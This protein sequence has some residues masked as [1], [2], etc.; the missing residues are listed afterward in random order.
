MKKYNITGMS[1]AACSTRIEKAVSNLDGVESCN[2]NL[3]TNSM[4]VSGNVSEEIIIETVKKTGYGASLDGEKKVTK[5]EDNDTKKLLKRLVLSLVFLVIL[6]YFSM[7]HMMFG[8][9]IPKFFEKNHVALGILEMLLTIVIMLI[10]NKFFTNG[11]KNLVRLSPNMDSLIAIGSGI[12]FAYSLYALFGLSEAVRVGNTEQAMKY[13]DNFHFETAAMI[14]TLITVGKTLESF[15]KGKTTNALKGLM[16]LTPKIATIVKDDKNIVVSIDEVRV[17]DIFLVRAGDIVP[18]DGVIIKGNGTIDESSLTGESIPIDKIVGDKVT[19]GTI[20]KSGF[21]NC[22]AEKVCEDTTL[23]QIIKMVEDAS[24]SKAPIAKIADKVAGIFVPVVI[25]IAILTFIIWMFINKNVIHALE[26]AVSVLVISCPC[27]LG[28]A[29]PV[30]IMVGNGLAAKNG[31]LFK[32]AES[33]ELTGRTKIIAFDKTGTITK[34]EPVVTD[35]F[36]VNSF[37]LNQ[38]LEVAYA[39]ENLSE[40]PI[41]KA[42]IKYAKEQKINLFEISDFKTISGLGLTAKLNDDTITAGNLKFIS[43]DIKIDD[44]IILIIE[45]YAKEGKT[46]I[47]FSKNDL[48]VGII[49]V[50]DSV[51]EDSVK[52]IKDLKSM[53]INVCMITGDNELT[54]NAIAKEVGIEHVYAG[55]LPNEKG[56]VINKLKE[57]GKVIMVGDGVNDAPALTS[58]NIGIAIGAGSDIAI[59][60]ADVVLVNSKLSDVVTAIK[61]SKITIW[62][63]Y[64][65][66]FWAFIYNII[67][68]P[69]AAGVYSSFLGWE[70]NPMIGAAAM[71]LSSF[72]VVCNALRLNFKKIK[73]NNSNNIK[74]VNKFYIEGMMCKHCELRVE[75]ILSQLAGVKSITAN[76]KKSQVII[77]ANK[78]IKYEDVEKLLENSEYKIKNEQK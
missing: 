6:M 57:Q 47:L 34:G 30:A 28:L 78:K 67:L 25:G 31:I 39:I 65:N 52:A 42:I 33:L 2:V 26:R 63:I 38:L 60:A 50:A 48:L 19:S 72:C 12:S 77:I 35:I 75:K 32:T 43:S 20:L 46:P 64:E 13:M 36:P 18:V 44:E 49:C 76:H 74:I 71:A 69:L 10:N 61:L 14:L 55:V 53:K 7:G 16:D 59:D 17:D 66:L 15:S 1:C 29:T 58:A 22:M 24:S 54:A 27:A 4:Q 70:L 23:S 56:K 68:I 11:F 8:F 73:D 51:K 21:L 41:S 3:L 5:I 37:S 45:K 62:N 40:H 9:K